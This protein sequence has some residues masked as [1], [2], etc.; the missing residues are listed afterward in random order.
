MLGSSGRG[1]VSGD[2]AVLCE[3]RGKPHGFSS[4]IDRD[5]VGPAEAEDG[6]AHGLLISMAETR[7]VDADQLLS[8]SL[9][10]SSFS[11]DSPA[12]AGPAFIK[13]FATPAYA[14]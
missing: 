13:S 5:C 10:E 3:S 6:R 11:E 2:P 12:S 1:L 8:A 14:S 9:P 4:Y 7:E